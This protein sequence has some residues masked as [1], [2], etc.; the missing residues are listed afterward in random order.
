[1]ENNNFTLELGYGLISL[2]DNNDPV[3][4]DGI[5]NLRKLKSQIP[6]IHIMDNMT[7][8]PFQ[9]CLNGEKYNL[10]NNDDYVSEVLNIILL[11]VEKQPES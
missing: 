8:E 5:T 6:R 7:L 10:R 3:L 11:F 2:V 9:I 4:L 1:M